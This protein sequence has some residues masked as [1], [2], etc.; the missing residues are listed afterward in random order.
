MN[1]SPFKS[2]FH[3]S[4]LFIKI[5]LSS[6]TLTYYKLTLKYRLS[7]K[8]NENKGFIFLYEKNKYFYIFFMIKSYFPIPFGHENL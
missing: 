8:F 3:I 6:N 4:F 7:F 1:F 5:V 2:F